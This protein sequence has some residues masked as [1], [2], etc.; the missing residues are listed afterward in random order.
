MSSECPMHPRPEFRECHHVGER[1]VE[2]HWDSG[3]GDWVAR[4]A[5]VGK[6]GSMSAFASKELDYMLQRLRESS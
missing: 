6:R 2:V 1:Y 4:S 5:T 3:F